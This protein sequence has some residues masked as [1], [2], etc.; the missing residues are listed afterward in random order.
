VENQFVF[1]YK[2]VRGKNLKMKNLMEK[3]TG[4]RKLSASLIPE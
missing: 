3:Q 2:G 4:G 1:D